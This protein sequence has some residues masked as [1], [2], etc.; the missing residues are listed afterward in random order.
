MDAYGRSKVVINEGGDRHRPITMRVFEATGSGAALLTDDLPGM[1]L[2]FDR[3]EEYA[4]L[5]DSRVLAQ[6]RELGRNGA[7][8]ADAGRNR[9]LT[10]HTYDHRVDDLL[11]VARGTTLRS[12]RVPTGWD[13]VLEPDVTTVV[14]VGADDVVDL[15]PDRAEIAIGRHADA[16]LVGDS[17]VEAIRAAVASA[18]RFV[19][20]VGG[21]RSREAVRSA[22]PEGAH[23]RETTVSHGSDDG[24]ALRTVMVV[25]KTPG[26]G[27]R[28][29]SE[30]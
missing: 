20:C 6:V 26:A 8:V 2:L 5:D 21:E 9:A 12:H 24:S 3:D 1:D 19:Y 22:L 29:G 27:Y 18:R 11:E 7:S 10:E 13:A 28:V 4:V 17:P 23:F 16:A 15:L 14:A 30:S 25:E